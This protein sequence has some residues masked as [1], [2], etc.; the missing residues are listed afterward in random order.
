MASESRYVPKKITISFDALDDLTEI[1]GVTAESSGPSGISVACA[2]PPDGNL[3][4]ADRITRRFRDALPLPQTA[5]LSANPGQGM[6]GVMGLD[7]EADWGAL[8][9]E[10]GLS[11]IAAPPV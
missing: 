8:G 3:D 6:G 10:T 4:H 5:H 9:C 2:T 11:R 7:G 1:L